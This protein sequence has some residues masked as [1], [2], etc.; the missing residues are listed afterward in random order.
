MLTIE[1]ES[2]IAPYDRAKFPHWD[3][4]DGDGMNTRL[5]VLEREKYR[6]WAGTHGGMVFGTKEKVA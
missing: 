4:E 1:P 2:A 6:G 3:D 5:E